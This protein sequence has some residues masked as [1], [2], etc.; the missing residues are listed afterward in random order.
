MKKLLETEK[1]I[2]EKNIHLE[3]NDIFGI[4]WYIIETGISIGS[5]RGVSSRPTH[6][7][8]VLASHIV[9]IQTL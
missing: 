7:K 9:R 8:F 1:F 6:N 5:W 3:K 2:N 4:K